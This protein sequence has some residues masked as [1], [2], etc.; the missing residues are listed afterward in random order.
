MNHNQANDAAQ[1]VFWWNKYGLSL[2]QTMDDVSL[3]DMAL[4]VNHDKNTIAADYDA[5]Y[6]IDELVT[7]VIKKTGVFDS[8]SSL[9]RREVVEI[10]LA[11]VVLPIYALDSMYNAIDVCDN[12]P[13][14][15]DTSEWDK[16][17]A[18]LIGFA[19]GRG[20]GVSDNGRLFYTL[21]NT[22][23]ASAGTCNESNIAKVNDL[24]M[25][26][27]NDGK[28]QLLSSNCA[29]AEEHIY[30]IEVYLQVSMNC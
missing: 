16:A 8:A 23:C 10:L 5:E 1:N 2:S 30:N 3:Y 4:A 19:E 11:T 6:P 18:S 26:E 28:D 9:E 27:F 29:S 17:V 25:A 21:A 14:Q 12:N 13:G 15:Q 20:D 24:L 22:L 7:S